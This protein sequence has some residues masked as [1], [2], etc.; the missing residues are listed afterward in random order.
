M[1]GT[2]ADRVRV[3][4]RRARCVDR[5]FDHL[6]DQPTR[7]RR[8]RSS[9]CSSTSRWRWPSR[10]SCAAVTGRRL[11]PARFVG[12]DR[13]SSAYGL[14]DAALSGSLRHSDDAFNTYRLAEPLGYWNAFGLVAAIGVASRRS[15]PSSH[16]RRRPLGARCRRAALPVLVIGLYF[17]F[18]RGSWLALFFGLA[19]TVA[20]DPRRIPAAL[21]RSPSSPRRRRSRVVDGVAPGCVDDR[22]R[23]RRDGCRRGIG[24][25]DGCSCSIPCSAALACACAV[26]VARRIPVG[27]PCATRRRRRAR[28]RA[29][30]VVARCGAR[31]G[32]RT[33]VGAGR[34][35]DERFDATGERPDSERP[36][37][38][39]LGH[40]PAQRP[41][42]S[43]GTPRM[44]VPSSGTGAGTF[45]ILWY[46]NRPSSQVVRDA[47]SL[48][49]ETFAELGARR[50]R[51]PLR[52]ARSFRSS[53]SYGRRRSRFVAPCVRRVPRVV[54]AASA[55]DW[56]WEMVGLTTTALLAGSACLVSAERRL[57]RTPAR[58]DAAR[59]SSV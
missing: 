42:E 43:P 8:A 54:S 45:E 44:S 19:A 33:P 56:H 29:V 24:S 48:Y 55:F 23:C 2:A 15:A 28:S 7:Y 40:R 37:V 4:R 52:R 1:P 51:A 11:P 3:A 58:G 18:S 36:P 20:L 9:E 41:F 35:R 30:V 34:E 14:A 39:S 50:A 27:T 22:G 53:P 25:A 12:I 17:T 38:H 32:R 13:R 57:A 26:C 16:A 47:H 46:E 5:A 6:V 59:C 31:G 21:D 49:V 10:S